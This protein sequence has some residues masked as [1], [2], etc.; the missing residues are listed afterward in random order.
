MTRP[1]IL[2]LGVAGTA[3][4]IFVIGMR[5][6]NA[7]VRWMGI[8]LMLSAFLLRFWKPRE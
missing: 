2:K 4:V 1:T 6:D 5:L 3:L 8:A 7:A